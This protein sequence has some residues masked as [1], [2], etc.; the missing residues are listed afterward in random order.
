MRK[1]IIA[2][3]KIQDGIASRQALFFHIA[4]GNITVYYDYKTIL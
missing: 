4:F 2:A 1:K 3:E